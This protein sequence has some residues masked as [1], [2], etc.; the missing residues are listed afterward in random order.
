[1][2]SNFHTDH[3]IYDNNTCHDIYNNINK[4]CNNYDAGNIYDVFNNSDNIVDRSPRC[5]SFNVYT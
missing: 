5:Y 2:A 4:I 1:M 3:N